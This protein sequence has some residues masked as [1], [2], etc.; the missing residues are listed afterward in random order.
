MDIQQIREKLIDDLG[1][2]IPEGDEFVIGYWARVAGML[3]TAHPGSE[4]TGGWNIADE[5]LAAER[6]G[7]GVA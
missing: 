6:A 1:V 3:R 7:L 2:S 5:E 4:F